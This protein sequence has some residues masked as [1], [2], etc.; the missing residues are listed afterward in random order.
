ME[1]SRPKK[2]VFE[3][4]VTFPAIVSLSR[5]EIRDLDEE[6]HHLP[7]L[8]FGGL[9]EGIQVRKVVSH[10]KLEDGGLRAH[11]ILTW[12]NVPIEAKLRRFKKY[13]WEAMVKAP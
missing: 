8:I 3:V 11:V 7:L 10:E 9:P 6:R 1:V 13:V 4:S 12:D 5:E 2:D